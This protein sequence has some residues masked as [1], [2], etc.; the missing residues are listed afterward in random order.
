MEV[1]LNFVN[2]IARS[3]NIEQKEFERNKNN[4]RIKENNKYK[5]VKDRE[6]KLKEIK[7]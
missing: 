5:K 6:E 7:T 1:I 2:F 4:E 3:K